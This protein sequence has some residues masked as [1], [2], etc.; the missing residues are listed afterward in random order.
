M[1]P[2]CGVCAAALPMPIAI[3]W[4]HGHGNGM[5][6]PSGC[7]WSMAHLGIAP[8]AACG[9]FENLDARTMSPNTNNPKFCAFSAPPKHAT[10][11]PPLFVLVFLFRAPSAKAWS[12]AQAASHAPHSPGCRSPP[13]DRLMAGIEPAES[14]H[15]RAADAHHMHA[16]HAHV[17][18]CM[19][20]QH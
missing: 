11:A 7:R 19:W 4:P 10:S 12:R 8:H 20:L 15:R 5:A 2:H 6:C 18:L 3:P 14:S 16:P 17:H 13:N 9:P 1:N